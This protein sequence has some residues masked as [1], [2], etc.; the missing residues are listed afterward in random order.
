[1]RSGIARRRPWALC[2]LGTNPLIRAG[3]RIE[4]L[5]VFLAVAC[6]VAAIPGALYIGERLYA[7]RAAR[8]S[9]Q[10]RTRH[11][12]EAMAVD[13][14]AVAAGR[15]TPVRAVQARWVTAF[16]ERVERVP[17]DRTVKVGDRLTVW[18]NSAGK[19][20]APPEVL[21]DSRGYIAAFAVMAAMGVTL[22]C[23]VLL[24]SVRGVLEG[25]RFRSWDR[26]WRLVIH[27]DD[28]LA[29]W[30]G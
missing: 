26:E 23:A 17:V 30:R 13:S 6:V 14:S 15:V 16:T 4:A 11:P 29:N 3:D 1:M 28:G 8:V 2:A 9:E 25:W 18:L 12:V 10:I 24:A 7:D 21:E 19:V 20:T 22:A 27:N 5:A